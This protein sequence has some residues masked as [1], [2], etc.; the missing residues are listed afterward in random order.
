V[1]CRI[2]A[3]GPPT[4]G[5]R[6]CK[7]PNWRIFAGLIL[8]ATL[9]PSQESAPTLDRIADRANHQNPYFSAQGLKAL[10][11][12]GAEALPALER[13]VQR[14]SI[15]AL[16]PLVVDWLGETPE[17]GA[18]RLL[19]TAL[20][21]RQ[22]P[23]RP[24]AARAL[25]K[26]VRPDE[27]DVVLALAKDPLPAVREPAF[28][29]LGDLASR[30]PELRAK[31]LPVLEAGLSDKLFEPRLA[32]AEALLK[33]KEKTPLPILVEALGVERRFFDLDF[34][35]LARRRAW[36]A[37]KPLAGEGVAYEPAVP[38]AKSAEAI[39]EIARR[40]DVKPGSRPT[41]PADVEDAIFGIELRSCRAGD[42]WIR[43][44]SSGELVLGHYDLERRKL[45]PARAAE[46]LKL[47]RATGAPESP[48]SRLAPGAYFGRP[49]CDFEKWYLPDE[50]ALVRLT[51]GLDG[52]PDALRA[53][54]EALGAAIEALW[55]ASVKQDFDDRAAPFAKPDE[56][57]D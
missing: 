3:C 6:F 25:A 50:A 39:A 46:L 19:R 11:T 4:S 2:F 53:L 32:A 12:K 24:Q 34:G 30:N 52:R 31:A 28:Q 40:L 37:L 5:F 57:E 45:E 41:L 55:G 21:D 18:R 17:D 33:L 44:T 38:P 7:L 8:L 15:L 42:Q 29:A 51:V 47:V 43:I 56:G 49:G 16:A 1:T 27:M 14:R 10:K 23:W 13:F 35:V 48:E 22:F 20:A 36:D 9:S 26:A 54:H